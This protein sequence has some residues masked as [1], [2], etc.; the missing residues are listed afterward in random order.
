[1]KKA[2]ERVGV[3]ETVTNG[4]PSPGQQAAS[5]LYSSLFFSQG[6]EGEDEWR[7]AKKG[8]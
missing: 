3:D 6:E 7:K 5:P 8:G 2:E 4:P 1:M